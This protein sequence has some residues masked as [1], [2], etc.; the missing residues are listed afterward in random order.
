M[1]TLEVNDDPTGA[2]FT[3][4]HARL[5]E[6]EAERQDRAAQL[7]QV[8]AEQLEA[9]DPELFDRLPLAD[10][11]VRQLPRDVQRRLF[12]AFR[13]QVRYH[14]DEHAVEVTAVIDE[15]AAETVRST[16]DNIVAFPV[17]RVRHRW[18]CLMCPVEESNLP[19][20]VKSRLLYR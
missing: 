3:R 7:A 14:R 9:P 11:D 13:L 16:G 17:D 10:I 8:E 5:T 15:R 19:Q 1:R 2:V 18:T 12:H 20:P 4:V 6:L